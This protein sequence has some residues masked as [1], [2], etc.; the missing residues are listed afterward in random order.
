MVPYFKKPCA[1]ERR[2]YKV[3]FIFLYYLTNYLTLI[4]KNLF[5]NIAIVIIT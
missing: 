1:A 4:W 3:R 5:G 2:K